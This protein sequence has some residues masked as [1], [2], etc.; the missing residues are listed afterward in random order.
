M[1]SI[2]SQTID[3]SPA[4]TG[5]EL[6]DSMY[7]FVRKNGFNPQVQPLAAGGINNLPYNIIV[8]FSPKD[9][10]SE[11]NFI[12]FFYMEDSWQNKDLLITVF[13]ALKEQKYNSTVVLSFGN[14]IPFQKE[15]VI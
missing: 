6:C 2:F 5:I 11:H 12:L 4:L 1:S 13:D 7:S 10:E 15:N 9:I 3:P 14:R 8:R